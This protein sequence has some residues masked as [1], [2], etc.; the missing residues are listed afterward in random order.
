VN[1]EDQVHCL[2]DCY[3]AVLKKDGRFDYRP[4]YLGVWN[5]YFEVNSSGI[6]YYSE[7]VDE[8]K[9]WRERF[10]LIYGISVNHWYRKHE[11]KRVNLTILS[12]LMK[13][14]EP[15]KHS[16]IM[17]DLFF[18]SYSYLFQSKHTPHFIIVDHLLEDRWY[19]IDPYFS[20]EGYISQAELWNA[21]MREGTGMTIDTRGINRLDVNSIS[22]LF[23][24]EMSISPNKL[25]LELDKLVRDSVENNGGYAP[26]TLLASIQHVAVISKRFG[27]YRYTLH[28]FLEGCTTEAEKGSLM[29]T[30]FV[31]GFESLMFILARYEILNRKVDLGLFAEKLERLN[32]LEVEIKQ[33]ITRAFTQWKTR[34]IAGCEA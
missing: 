22:R 21:F 10:E 19:V 16:I 3:A 20:W 34:E 18:L 1:K 2:L 13:N 17:V 6:S 15:H 11:E 28:Y 27:G 26:K 14:N 5:A 24:E 29:I 31:R 7:T 9:K 8:L 32:K 23:E 25:L 4:F 33:E 30:E 12:D